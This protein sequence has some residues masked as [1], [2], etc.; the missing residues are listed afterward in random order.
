MA[1]LDGWT[2][3]AGATLI[4]AFGNFQDDFTGRKDDLD[5]DAIPVPHAYVMYGKDRWSVGL[6]FFVPYGLGTNWNT[7]FEGR[8][9]GFN[10]DLK[11]LYFQPSA[12]FQVTD[13]LTLGAGF[14]FVIGSLEITQRLD[15]STQPVPGL[16]GTLFGDIGIPF[17]TD[18]A[19]AKLH[20]SEAIGFGGNFGVMVQPVPQLQIGARYLTRVKLDYE[21]TAT[22]VQVQNGLI[23]P[24]FNPIALADT[25]IDPTQPLPL[26]LV[27]AGA[28]LFAPGATLSNQTV[29][30]SITMPDQITLGLA[31]DVTPALKLLGEWQWVHWSLLD[32]IVGEFDF[33]PDLVL[34]ENYRDTHGFRF[35]LDWMVSHKVNLRGGYLHHQG[36]APD[37]T[38]TPLLPEG[39][40]NEFTGGVGIRFSDHW[41]LDLAYQYIRQDKR[42]G[43]VR[44]AF[45]GDSPTTDLNSGVYTF[46]AHLFGAT[47]TARF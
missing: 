8:F 1:T 30:A 29:T 18:F 11:S 21:G 5:N 20:A 24:P 17:H 13:W 42:R 40:R 46:N 47:L 34:E 7:D 37:E 26:D 41:I 45:P 19:E 9:L 36:A 32:S 43:R 3:T 4:Y 25:S 2:V 35:G 31:F 16:G 38:V 23:L 6:G 10:N 33:A 22:F 39:D 44:E 14:D 12:A 27:V 15:F 28:G